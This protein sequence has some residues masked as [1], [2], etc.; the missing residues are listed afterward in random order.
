MLRYKLSAS[1]NDGK[2]DPPSITLEVESVSELDW[3]IQGQLVN[4]YGEPFG[5]GATLVIERIG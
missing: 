2:N 5:I 3:Q 4:D 1:L